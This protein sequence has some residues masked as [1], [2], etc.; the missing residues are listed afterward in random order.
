MSDTFFTASPHWAWWIVFYFFVGGIAGSAFLLA[1]LLHLAG[2]PAVRPLVRL[3]YYTAFVGVPPF[4]V[5]ASLHNCR[6]AGCH[7]HC[8]PSRRSGG[9]E[10]LKL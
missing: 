3:G 9:D 2:R 1:S 6:I 4:S 7:H 5:F 8:Q 10:I